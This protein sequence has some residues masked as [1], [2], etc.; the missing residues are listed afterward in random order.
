M[1][2][3]VNP[4]IRRTVNPLLKYENKR[5]II[6]VIVSPKMWGKI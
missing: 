2:V 4:N 1:L 5:N 3:I 6:L